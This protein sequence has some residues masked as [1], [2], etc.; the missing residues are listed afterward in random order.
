MS[1]TKSEYL[2]GILAWGGITT[3]YPFTAMGTEDVL[4]QMLAENLLKHIDPKDGW[5]R[6]EITRKGIEYVATLDRE[7]GR[8]P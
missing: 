2:K 4:E 7:G 1:L 5:D 3:I 6:Y 8:L